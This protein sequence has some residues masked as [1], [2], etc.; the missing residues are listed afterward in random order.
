MPELIFSKHKEDLLLLAINRYEEISSNRNDIC[1]EGEYLQISTKKLPK[2]TTFK[3]HKHNK[4]NRTTEI[5]QE[6]WIIFEGKILA[7]FWD[8][9]DTIIYETI[10]KKGDCAVVFKA[11]HSFKVLEENTILYEVKSGPYFGVEKDK[12]FIGEN[13]EI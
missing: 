5:T 8:I 3:P 7:S 12:T 9:D 1:P 4:L 11:G 2:N 10:L 13:Y 6:A